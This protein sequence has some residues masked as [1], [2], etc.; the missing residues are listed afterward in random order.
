MI[1]IVGD[2]GWC[3]GD[4]DDIF[5]DGGGEDGDDGKRRDDGW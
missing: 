5:S 3:R 1:E 2:Q 4:N